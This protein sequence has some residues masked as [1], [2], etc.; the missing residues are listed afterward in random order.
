MGMSTLSD[1]YT[2]DLADIES[3]SGTARLSSDAQ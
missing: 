3:R 1:G 2:N